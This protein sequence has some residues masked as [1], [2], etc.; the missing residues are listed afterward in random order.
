MVD[1]NRPLHEMTFTELRGCYAELH[2]VCEDYRKHVE[3]EKARRLYYQSIVFSV[4]NSIDR[5]RQGKLVCGTID[6]PS[7]QVE[8]A[9]KALVAEVKR[10]TAELQGKNHTRLDQLE[11]DIA[12]HSKIIEQLQE[13]VQVG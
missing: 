6:E 10:L 11:R 8:E 5:V 1:S 4:C 12:R 3:D 9:A 7:T 13:G 2:Q